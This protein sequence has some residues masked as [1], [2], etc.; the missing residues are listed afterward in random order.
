M[1]TVVCAWCGVTIRTGIQRDKISH[2]ICEDCAE[3]MLEEAKRA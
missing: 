2:G 3:A 1:M